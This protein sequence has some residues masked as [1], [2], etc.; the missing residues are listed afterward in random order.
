MSL[1]AVLPVKRFELAKSRL[2]YGGLRPADRLALATGM[3]NDVLEAL[4]R[5]R[6]VDD[7]VVVTS[8][9]GAEVLARSYGAQSI[10]DDPSGGHNGA[11]A[12]GIAWAL[13]DGALQALVL[14]GD[15]PTLDPAELNALIDSG[16]DG[17]EVV[18]VPDRHGTGTN[19]LL[20]SPPDVITTSF[21]EGSRERH[22]RLAREAGATATIAEPRSLLLDVDTTDDLKALA[23][24]LAELP[25][26]VAP[27]TRTAL[28]RCERP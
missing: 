25:R 18:I 6:R 15:A 7:I 13:A 9:P 11:V 8:E 17:P 28:S 21:G 19:A 2:G 24:R 27:F 14:P 26:D 22:E 3:L 16:S 20:L 23:A 1:V 10:A 12:L 4:R 5:S